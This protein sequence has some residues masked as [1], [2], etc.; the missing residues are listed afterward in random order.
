MFAKIGDLTSS[1]ISS[2]KNLPLIST[3]KSSEIVEVK[4]RKSQK[5]LRDL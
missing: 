1:I 2:E 3:L 4:V 5:Q